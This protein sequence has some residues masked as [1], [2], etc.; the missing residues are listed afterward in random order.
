VVGLVAAC[1]ALQPYDDA[2]I[3]PD[4]IVVAFAAVGT[5]S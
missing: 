3:V 2:L 5:W 1:Y 4:G